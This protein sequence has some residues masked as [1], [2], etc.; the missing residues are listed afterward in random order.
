MAILTIHAAVLSGL[1]SFY[2]AA[3]TKADLAIPA[4]A[5]T[6]VVIAFGLSYFYSAAVVTETLSANLQHLYNLLILKTAAV[7]FPPQ[8][9]F[10]LFHQHFSVIYKLRA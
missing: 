6:M 2:V 10:K 7:F 9:D 3:V 5:T 1:L 4:A 8:F